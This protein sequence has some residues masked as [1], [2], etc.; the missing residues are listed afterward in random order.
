MNVH[1]VPQVAAEVGSSAALAQ[2][3]VPWWRT[4]CGEPE[5]A[6]VVAAMRAERISAGPVVRELEEA[7]A[8]TLGVPYVICTT[9]GSMALTMALIALGVGS[10]DEVIVPNRTF[11]ATAHAALV[12]GAKV[13]LVDVRSDIPALDVAQV[14]AA[15]TPR[16]KVVMPVHLNGR[17]VDMPALNALAKRHNLKV[18]EDAAQA[19]LS[20]GSAGFLGTQSDIGCFSLGMTKLVSTGQGG[21]VV[22]R[23][24]SL[25][26][27]LRRVQCHGVVDTL[28][29]TY[30]ML[31]SNFKFNDVLAS[32]GV[33]QLQRGSDKVAHVS[34]VYRAYRQELDRLQYLEIIP[35]MVEQGEV[36]LW[37]EL[38]V[39]G[40][41]EERAHLM[42]FLAARGI[43]TR[44]FL[45]D[46]H[47]SPYLDNVCGDFPH[48]RRY[49]ECGM[50]LP[51]GPAQPMDNVYR[52]IEALH[53]YPKVH[54][55][56]A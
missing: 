43:H 16:T 49:H 9:S 32:I 23:D 13:R 5:I 44:R 51:G 40:G 17:A 36:P 27:R 11:M 48:S 15:I 25:Y 41:A 22:T 20:K 56:A 4:E 8:R 33:I 26:Q 10:G 34:T 7:I 55:R 35:V 45:P 18:V 53:E 19:F 39:T 31:G 50:F 42:A 38:N 1:A 54:L 52:T 2:A 28:T 37:T 12:L 46:L 14:E 3:E 30:E 29:D 6:K 24:E 47:R 21:F